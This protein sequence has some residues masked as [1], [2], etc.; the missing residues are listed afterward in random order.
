VSPARGPVDRREGVRLLVAD[1]RTGSLSDRDFSDFSE[2]LAPGDVLVVNDAATLPASLVGTTVGGE[3]LELRLLEP[4]LAEGGRARRP[5]R[6][7]LL[8]L[9]DFRLDT[10]DRAEPPSIASGD[11]IRLG[12]RLEARVT[13]VHEDGHS[14]ELVFNATGHELIDA[15]YRAGSP[16]QYSH[17][18]SPIALWSFQTIYGGRPWSVEMPSAGRPL[19]GSM[20]IELRRRGIAVVRITHAAGLSA[21][22]SRSLDASLP[23]RERYAIPARTVEAIERAHA[24][25]GRVIAVGTSVVRALESAARAGSLRA[26]A[27]ETD[28]RIDGSFRPRVADG[29]LT[30]MHEPGESHYDLLQAFAPPDLLRRMGE[31]ANAKAYRSH[32]FG[33]VTLLLPRREPSGLRESPGPRQPSGTTFLRPQPVMSLYV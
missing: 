4:P 5:V 23:L 15:L 29:I 14:L 2:F 32:E 7:V 27:R 16:V 19:T 28:L 1:Q 8:G 17:H 11:V 10:N 9:G 26:G 13:D 31:H 24:R 3:A 21:T 25:G 20:L 33:D 22:G 18:G 30:G 12:G 6:A